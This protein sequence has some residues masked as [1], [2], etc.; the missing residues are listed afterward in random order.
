MKHKLAFADH[1]AEF[2]SGSG[3]DRAM[4]FELAMTNL[5]NRPTLRAF[6]QAYATAVQIGSRDSAD[7]I[8]SSA[9]ERWG[10]TAAFRQSPFASCMANLFAVTPT[11]SAMASDTQPEL[12]GGVL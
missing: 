8:L 1:A 12:K 5:G 7:E 11:C 2:Y 10:E 4:A 9:K 3:N 6:E